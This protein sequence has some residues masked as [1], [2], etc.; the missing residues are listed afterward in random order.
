MRTW[1][2]GSCVWTGDGQRRLLGH[3]LPVSSCGGRLVPPADSGPDPV[4]GSIPLPSTIKPTTTASTLSRR[5]LRGVVTGQVAPRPLILLGEAL[6]G[7]RVVGC[8]LKP[9]GTGA[10]VKLGGASAQWASVVRRRH[11]ELSR[12]LRAPA[13][14]ARR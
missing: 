4:S 11:Q 14:A 1:I 6:L 10:S 7:G 13:A 2:V 8:S 3:A 9:F 5:S 12:M